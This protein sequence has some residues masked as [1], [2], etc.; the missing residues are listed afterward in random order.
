MKKNIV[1]LFVTA[2]IVLTACASNT[3]TSSIDETSVEE[4]SVES[5]D[6]ASSEGSSEEIA[7][8]LNLE[9]IL[10]DSLEEGEVAAAPGAEVNIGVVGNPPEVDIKWTE[11][12]NTNPDTCAYIVVPGTSI[13]QVVLKKSDSNEYYLEHDS[14]GADSVTGSIL[15]DMGNETDFTDPN[16]CLYGKAGAGCPLEELVNY[17]DATFFKEHP[18]IYLYTPDYVT[19]YRVFAAYNTDD[20][21]RLLVKYDFYNYD[22][23]ISYVDSI[24]TM[25]DMTA[26]LDTDIE[27]AVMSIWNILTITGIG[28]DGNRFIVQGVFNGRSTTY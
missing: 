17:Q 10:P 21:E 25:R 24:F 2:S 9:E 18:Y 8:E 13:N 27:G 28:D 7:E 1:M 23:Y 4:I 20:A 14:T 3:D 22:E 11:L 16:T 12:N 19:E 6:D 5:K 15:M 26:V